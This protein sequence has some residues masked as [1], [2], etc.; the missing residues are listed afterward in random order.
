MDVLPWLAPAM[1][2]AM[3][4]ITRLTSSLRQYVL[5][6]VVAPKQASRALGEASS[7]DMLDS[8]L[9]RVETD[10]ALEDSEVK[11]DLELALFAL[12]DM[13]GGHSAVANVAL[14]ALIDLGARPAVQ[15][16]LSPLSSPSEA[17]LPVLPT[18]VTS[19]C[20]GRAEEGG[21]GGPARI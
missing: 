20:T 6:E 4:E 21:R 1:R 3:A 8:W 14:R 13:L 11:I 16:H 19:S 9:D 15:V 12:E 10:A 7:P 17:I 5:T 2:G 18:S